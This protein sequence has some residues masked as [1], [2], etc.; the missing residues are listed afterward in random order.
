MRFKG[1]ENYESNRHRTTGGRSGQNRHSKG[2]QK[3]PTHPR[4]R[5][6]ADIIDTVGEILLFYVGFGEEAGVVGVHRNDEWSRWFY[7]KKQHRPV[8]TQERL[9]GGFVF[10]KAEAFFDLIVAL[11]FKICYSYNYL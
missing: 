3:N 9:P 11:F 10:K 5:P 7:K 6:V 8:G 4:G 1:E 2:D